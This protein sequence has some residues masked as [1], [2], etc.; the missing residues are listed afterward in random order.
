MRL[1]RPLI[2]AFLLV[3]ILA[4]AGCSASG[5]VA[6]PTPEPTPTPVRPM[7]PTFTPTPTATPQ[8]A[9]PAST[10]EEAT[11]TP[12]A[13]APP[14]AAAETPTPEPTATPTPVTSPTPTPTPTPYISV[15]RTRVN[16]RSGPGTAYPLVGQ[17]A[18]GSKAPI[19]ARD[20]SG[21]WWQICCVD[22]QEAWI[23]GWVVEV[24]ND[25]ANVPIAQNIPTPP[26]T[27]T[28]RA[29]PTP[30]P[31][32]PPAFTF[33]KVFGPHP[34][35]S[36][37]PVMTVWVKVADST[38]EV[39]IG[40]V[41]ARLYFGGQVVAESTAMG[42][43]GYTRPGPE[44]GF[45]FPYNVKLEV[46]NPPSGEFQLVI[47]EGGREVSPRIPFIRG[48]EAPGAEIYFEFRRK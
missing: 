1:Q 23:A 3:V 16:V 28:P 39:P 29:T 14:P 20:P 46:F 8:A 27:P 47:V 41:Q 11:N 21:K 13:E 33:E 10:G 31:T 37:N 2:L 48:S 6:P 38:G 36:T 9:Q 45:F 19:V 15:E 17:L 12:T 5:L 25:T 34:I 30:K 32:P 26:P 18:Q 24:H 22:G 7:V 40:G 44:H 4:L 35:L 43:F 42:A